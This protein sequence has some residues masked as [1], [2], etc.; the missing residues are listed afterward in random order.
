MEYLLVAIIIG[1]GLW[2]FASSRKKPEGLTKEQ[3]LLRVAAGLQG[4]E[5]I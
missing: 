4:L 5:S 1:A 3:E 2:V